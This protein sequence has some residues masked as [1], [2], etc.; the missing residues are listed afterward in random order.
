MK[1]ITKAIKRTPHLVT[2][3]VGMSKKSVDPEFDDYQR[4]FASL[5][6]ATEKLLKDTK[7]FTDAVNHLFT[8][9]ASF[10]AHFNAL[11][12]PIAGE[13]D[14]LGKHPDCAHTIRN[15]DAYQAAL[16]E[17]RGSVAPELELIE[18]RIHGPLKEY[19]GV[20]KTVRKTITK[21][22]HKLVDYDRYNNS[23]T[24]LRDK[25][26]KSLSDEKNL[27]KLE[28]D[29]ENASNEYDYINTALK[30]DLPRFM[31][32]STQFI[33]P[34]F[35][36]FFY[37]QLNIFYL[38]L[39]KLQG[40]AEGKYDTSVTGAQIA[41]EY[42][43]KRSDAWQTIEGLHITQRIIS[44]SKLVQQ[45]RTNGGLSPS[46]SSLNR[47]ASATSTASGASRSVSGA[48]YKK[49]PPPPP[50]GKAAEPAPPPYSPPANG[51]AAAAA[52]A[53]KRAPPPPPPPLKP[54]PKAEPP[55]QYVVA[56]Y[57]FEA[58]AEGDLSFSAG[59]RIELVEKT[60]S[61][62]DWWTGRLNGR[63]GVFPGNYV[64][65]T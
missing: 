2:T 18:S 25:K 17:L 34:L 33:D 58:Q 48:G 35:H 11:F 50:G 12:H 63:Q 47:S 29:F 60:E 41:E 44:T 30:N 10:A 9:G 57:D 22:E 7:A 46:P 21:R 59:D 16:E 62:E 37:M 26:E 27:F 65:E 8:S 24:K 20:L 43:T 5:E 55:V 31:T 53:A 64:Q 42:E 38:L 49:A 23:L 56:L 32:M 3:K 40:F 28:Q 13:Y 6:Q 19:Q 52:A 39:E 61:Q 1:G 54:K 4:R 45:N 36:S 14:L 51:A 15:V